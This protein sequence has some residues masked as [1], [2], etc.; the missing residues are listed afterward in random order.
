MV[1]KSLVAQ[2]VRIYAQGAEATVAHLRTH[3]G[4]RDVDLIVERSDGRVLAIDVTLGGAHDDDDVRSL[5]WL[6]DRLGDDPLDAIVVNSGPGANYRPD[7]IGVVPA[8]LL[9]P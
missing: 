2:S 9:G 3:D 1:F 4:R 7:G 5:R 8:A 6:A